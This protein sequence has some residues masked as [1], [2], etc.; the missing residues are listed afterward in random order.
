MNFQKIIDLKLLQI[1]W[2]IFARV[3][4]KLRYREEI[5]NQWSDI[6][7]SASLS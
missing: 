2:R 7:S 5:P 1:S 4:T 3:A 6:V